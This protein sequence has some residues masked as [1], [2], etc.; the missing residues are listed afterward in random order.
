MRLKLIVFKDKD[1]VS[2]MLDERGSTNAP[3]VPTYERGHRWTDTVQFT[4]FGMD[5]PN[6]KAIIKTSLPDWRNGK[7]DGKI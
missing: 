3:V 7:F 5:L 4:R 1:R 6:R 2:L